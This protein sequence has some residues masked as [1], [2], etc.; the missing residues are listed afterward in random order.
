MIIDCK[1][2]VFFANAGDGQYSNERS[3]GEGEW[4]ETLKNTTRRPPEQV[5]RLCL[6]PFALKVACD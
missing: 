6:D 3:E 1:T 2:V 4:G 5:D